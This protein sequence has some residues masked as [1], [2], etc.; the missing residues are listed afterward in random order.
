MQRRV[1]VRAVMS[2]MAAPKLLLGQA[3]N[4]APPPPAPVPWMTGLNAATPVPATEIAEAVAEADLHFFTPAQMATLG[5]L[6]DV[7]VPPLADKPGALAAGAPAFLDFL[8]STSAI[9]RKQ[10]YKG[11][12]DWLEAESKK[13]FSMSF[14]QLDAAQAD[15]ILRPWLRTWM[16]DHPPT[17]PHADFVNIAHA[18]IRTA[19]VN[20]QVWSEASTD[21]AQETR[22]AGLYWY[23]I[24]PD[25]SRERTARVPTTQAGVLSGSKAHP[26]SRTHNSGRAK[27]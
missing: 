1:F 10:M 18:D 20:S 27:N 14:A 4:P 7:M 25:L 17:E 16:S 15:R 22:H 6:S 3:A 12:L 2:A 19:T 26:L 9:D 13:Q 11:G 8:V 23:P 21:A 5:R 24:E